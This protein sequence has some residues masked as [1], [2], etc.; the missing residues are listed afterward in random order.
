MEQVAKAIEDS[1]PALVASVTEAITAQ[2]DKVAALVSQCTEA[3]DKLEK[4]VAA[5]KS[6]PTAAPVSMEGLD[7]LTSSVRE[8]RRE[9]NDIES[10]R[11]SSGDQRQAE[12]Q[13]LMD[14]VMK[15]IKSIPTPQR[16]VSFTMKRDDYNRVTDVVANY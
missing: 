4:A 9:L 10:R 7:D 12:H 11:I 3:Q 1:R 15:A 5:I 8:I 2:C 6:T 14:S 16:P 13:A